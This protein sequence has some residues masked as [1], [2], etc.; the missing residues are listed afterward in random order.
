[1]RDIGRYDV[2][3]ACAEAV[4]LTTDGHFQFTVDEVSDLFVDVF[5]FGEGATFFGLPEGQGTTGTVDHFSEKAGDD[6][7]GGDIV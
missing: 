4:F 7:F 1:M 3:V 5:V 2:N 6:L